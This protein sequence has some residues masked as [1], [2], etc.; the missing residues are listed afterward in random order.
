MV[1][2]LHSGCAWNLKFPADKQNTRWVHC[3]YFFVCTYK[4]LLIYLCITQEGA[5][6]F[7]KLVLFGFYISVLSR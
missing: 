1:F 4:G 2:M 5:L 7:I 3:N 6:G